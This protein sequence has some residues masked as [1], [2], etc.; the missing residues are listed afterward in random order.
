[1]EIEKNESVKE[2]KNNC[3]TENNNYCWPFIDLF[4]YEMGPGLHN[5]CETQIDNIGEIP[6]KIFNPNSGQCF[7]GFR[8]FSEEEISFFHNDWQKSEFFPPQKVNFLG[9]DCNIPRNPDYFLSRN[10]DKNYMTEFKKPLV[11]HRIEKIL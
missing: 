1:M 9:I 7:E 4:V 8:L 2:W 11:V 10:Y 3:I 5:C 6:I